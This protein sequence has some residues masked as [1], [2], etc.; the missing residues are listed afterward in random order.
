MKKKKGVPLA[1]GCVVRSAPLPLLVTGGGDRGLRGGKILESWQWQ[2][3]I[4]LGGSPRRSL[5]S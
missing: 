1:R 4:T 2:T 3:L 5:R